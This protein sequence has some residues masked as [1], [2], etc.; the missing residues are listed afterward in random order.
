[1]LVSA[2][3]LAAIAPHHALQTPA[4]AAFEALCSVNRRS[5]ADQKRRWQR[6]LDS[7]APEFRGISFRGKNSKSVLAGFE[8]ALHSAHLYIEQWEDKP[9][10]GLY[11]PNNDPC[12]ALK[13]T[14]DGAI[15]LITARI[16]PDKWDNV[17]CLALLR[18][19]GQEWK[20][21]VIAANSDVYDLIWPQD[22]LI[23]GGRLWIGGEMGWPGN[24][25]VEAA[26]AYQKSDDSWSRF[27][28]IQ[29]AYQTESSVRLV[30][31]AK[32]S[33]PAPVKVVSRTYPKN[34]D[35][36]HATA[37]L[38]YEERWAF[39][40]GKPTLVWRR[41]ADTAYNALDSLYGAYTDRD[42]KRVRSLCATE[43]LAK[44]IL[45]LKEGTT[46]YP[47][48]S[49]PPPYVRIHASKIGINSLHT[50]FHFARRGSRWVVVKLS[51]LKES[52]LG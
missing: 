17:G 25:S 7:L 13:G 14:S 42:A 49:F 32:N 52:D 43:G 3:L 9:K 45:S 1:M 16:S 50:W 48:T 31:D 26:W 15:A 18:K 11:L 6:M 39:P 37:C 12:C 38:A 33:C 23:H 47:D 41:R 36:C 35:A 29:S 28:A 8:R 2:L 34:L 21:E 24:A 20:A 51:P 5:Q 10:P 27:G 19:A 22:A 46:R 44:R 40:N 4:Q 30:L